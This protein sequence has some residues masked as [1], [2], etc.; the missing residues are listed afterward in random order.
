MRRIAT[1]LAVVAACSLGVSTARAGVGCCSKKAGAQKTKMAKATCSAKKACADADAFPTMV[2]LVGE[3]TVTCP[4]A[5]K[6]LA[7]ESGQKVIYVVGDKKFQCCQAATTALADRSE[8]YLNKF[9]TIACVVDGKVIDC[10]QKCGDGPGCGGAKAKLSS[11]G[12]KACSKTCA[13]AAKLAAAKDKACSKTCN[14]KRAMAKGKTCPFAAA[15]LAK[16]GGKACCKAGAKKAKLASADGKACSKTCNAKMAMAKGKT[17]PFAA[18]KMAKA[19]GKACCKAGAKKAKLAAAN[20]RTC[21]KTCTKAAKLAK[22]GG[23]SGY[24]AGYKAGYA[25]GYAAATHDSLVKVHGRSWLQQGKTVK[26]RVAGRDFDTWA[27][28]VRARDRAV[29]AVKKVNM[30]FIVDGKEVACS[31]QVCPKAKAAG[32]VQF[33]VSGQKMQCEIKARA[34]LARA[35]CQAAQ[36]ACSEL[37]AQK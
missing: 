31:S 5:A 25:A 33:V 24:H 15:K 36:T 21:S 37:L 6:K 32:K 1:I 19:G 27:D 8:A 9:L 11:A 14:A 26:Y 20:G 29:A 17:C 10:D 2:Q 35:Q 16:A 22:T 13:K 34:A 23:K 12:G 30:T 18:A 28:A 3:K 7:Q 4:I